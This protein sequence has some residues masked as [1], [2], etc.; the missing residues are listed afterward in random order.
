MSKSKPVDIESISENLYQ[1]T[2]KMSGL[3]WLI[4]CQGH[5]EQIPECPQETMLGISLIVQDLRDEVYDAAEKLE[6]HK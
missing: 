2:R 5:F 3:A 4:E 6:T 1:V